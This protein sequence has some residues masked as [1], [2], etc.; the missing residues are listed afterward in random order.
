[1]RS[2]LDTV[3]SCGEGTFG[4]IIPC[5][6][7]YSNA[8]N[9]TRAIDACFWFVNRTRSFEVFMGWKVMMFSPFAD[10]I[11]GVLCKPETSDQSCPVQYWTVNCV[12]GLKFTPS[13]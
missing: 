2:W 7:S 13:A 4:K 11:C 3:K 9:S 10:G 5:G 12:G 6:N 1:M 8:F